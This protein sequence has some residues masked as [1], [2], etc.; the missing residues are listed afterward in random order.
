MAPSNVLS[1][2]LRIRRRAMTIIELLVVICIL[3]ILVSLLLVGLQ[4]SREASRRMACASNLRQ[5]GLAVHQY[6]A[7]HRM[8]PPGSDSQGFGFL[9]SLLPSLDLDDVWEQIRFSEYPDVEN[10]I[11]RRLSVPPFHC[12]SD[13][14]RLPTHDAT[15]NYAGNFGTGVQKY[16]YNGMFRS[17]NAKVV[18]KTCGPVR[19]AD[20]SNGLAYVA[21]ISELLPGTG[22][23]RDPRVIWMTQDNLVSPSELEAFRTQ[24]LSRA[25]RHDPVSGLPVGDLYSRGRPWIHGD[26]AITWYNHIVPPNSVNCYNGTLIQQGAYC[27]ASSH[28][29]GVN[30]MYADSHVSFVADTVERS[31]WTRAGARDPLEE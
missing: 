1:T 21:C 20:I 28:P 25:F 23:R 12:P 19:H 27:A 7:V 11:A 24:C 3:G 13:S 9:V 17:L 4:W 29:S 2:D 30:L 10:K 18:G 5:L 16:G 8:F 15:A 14:E 31:V 26:A 22:K 6:E